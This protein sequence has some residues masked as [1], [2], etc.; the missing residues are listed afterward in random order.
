MQREKAHQLTVRF[1]STGI[2]T[3]CPA[4]RRN[5]GIQV[6]AL[7]MCLRKRD[8]RLESDLGEPSSLRQEEVLVA[9]RKQVAQVEI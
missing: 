3:H 2:Q 9:S 8:K 5:R 1:L 4:R 6:S 7:L